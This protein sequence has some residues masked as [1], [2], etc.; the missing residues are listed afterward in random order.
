MYQIH[1]KYTQNVKVAKVTAPKQHYVKIH[2]L[3]EGNDPCI[4]ILGLHGMSGYLQTLVALSSR[5]KPAAPTGQNVRNILYM[6]RTEY[7]SSQQLLIQQSW[8]TELP[9]TQKI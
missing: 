9:R 7:F 5:R 3:S 6:M 4:F 2:G 8:L 1:K